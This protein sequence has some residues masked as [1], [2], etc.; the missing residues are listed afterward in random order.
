MPA[1]LKG[2]GYKIIIQPA[3]LCGSKCWT[4]TKKHMYVYD[5]GSRN[6]YVKMDVW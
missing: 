1:R 2:K 6:T 4:T 3:I 5:S